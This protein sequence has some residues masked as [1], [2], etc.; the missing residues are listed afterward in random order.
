VAHS[1]AGIPAR[2]YTAANPANV[3]GLITLGTPHGGSPLT[4]L[5]DPNLGNVLRLVQRLMPA[6]LPDDPV[7]SALTHLLRALDG[8]TTSPTAGSLPVPSIYPAGDF[9][10]TSG[11]PADTGG[12]PALALGGT[13]TGNLLALTSSWATALGTSA[14][15]PA[16]P[17][18]APTHLGFGMRVHAGLPAPALGD[19]AIDSSLRFD[20]CR[21]KLSSAAEEP[22]RPAQGIRVR[23]KISRPGGWLVGAS[24]SFGGAGSAPLDVRV[25]WAE[26]GVDFSPGTS[27]PVSTPQV[28]LH[29]ASY[30][31][32]VT[33]LVSF[34]DAQ[35][36]PLLGAVLQTVSATPPAAG[37]GL[38][39]WLA[40]MQALK[41][42]VPDP[43]GGL[44][45]S[46]DAWNAIAANASTFLSDQLASALNSGT[47]AGFTGTNPWVSTVPGMP[48]EIYV[49]NSP[50]TIGLRTTT[51]RLALAANASVSF[52]GHL[53]FSPASAALEATL[54]VGAFA[55]K[56]S[57]AN[58]QLTAQAPPWLASL[59][60][61]PF[62]AGKFA[63]ALK[64]AL[65][66]LLFSAT[67]SA[68]FESIIGTSLSIGPLDTFFSAPATAINDPGG[69]LGA[70]G[71]GLDPA[72]L[73]ALLQAINSAVGSGSGD[74]WILPAG[75][76]LSVTG[77]NTP[78]QPTTLQLKTTTKIGG[79]LDLALDAAFDRNL[80]VTPGGTI[81]LN[82]DLGAGVVWSPIAIDFSVSPAGVTLS[83]KPN[84]VAAVQLLPTVSGLS[85]LAAG[86][87]A[88]LPGI[89]DNLLPPN[90]ATGSALL[91]AVLDVARAFQLYDDG[92]HFSAHTPQF[93][94]LLETNWTSAAALTSTAQQA[95][96]TA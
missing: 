16:V 72:K 37:S 23:T 84:G 8:Y 40:W 27:G 49:S 3:Q 62:D 28:L 92:G 71:G 90:P 83:V 79:I 69:S 2:V 17:P 94:A 89:L 59:Q 55:L 80:H 9:N 96:A 68:I 43:H 4:F 39:Q 45:I 10:F 76:Q 87:T 64:D 34:L 31:G 26:V 7:T 74:A 47:F 35:A 38:A 66:R 33:S 85:N 57:T 50:G 36:Q 1:T 12:K 61:F 42:V 77:N 6:T 60:L 30:H 91:Q 70:A 78:A 54:N 86:A 67:A 56:W 13:L 58:S 48:F 81:S 15:S 32:P 88:L 41:I 25:R 5:T 29:D 93:Q 73:T 24:S 14:A 19:V 11:D 51:A 46:A 95:I 18:P 22:A 63:A 65:P 82:A 20:A 75:L 52:D 53:A 21:V 44:G